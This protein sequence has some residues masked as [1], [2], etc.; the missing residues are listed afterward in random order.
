MSLQIDKETAKRV[1]H[2]AAELASR[3]ATSPEW[4]RRVREL[5]EA[6][7]KAP[8]THITFLG[9]ALLA[10]AVD[11][12]ADAFA[13]KAS[14]G[15]PGA[16]S[17]RTL[18]HGVLVSSA[19]ALGIDLGRTGREPLNNQPYF[20]HARVTPE[21]VIHLSARE[22]VKLL[23]N[24]LDELDRIESPQE[25]LGALAS[26][27]AVRREYRTTYRVYEPG[28]IQL[29]P[30]AFAAAIDAFVRSDSEGGRRAHSTH[31]DHFVHAIVI[32]HSRAS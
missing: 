7:E 26:F 11:I 15:T 24:I 23:L 30:A 19:P 31:R 21:M 14:A 4:E 18:G 10:K 22:A 32:T 6:C 20:R 8:K 27:I 13:I 16:Y 2:R 1:L 12:R 5:S 17:A 29:T 3:G 28:E 9:T 25:A